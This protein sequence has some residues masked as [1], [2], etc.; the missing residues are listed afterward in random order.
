MLVLV[1]TKRLFNCELPALTTTTQTLVT[2]LLL[3]FYIIVVQYFNGNDELIDHPLNTRAN[4][5]RCGFFSILCCQ[6]IEMEQLT[7]DK[8]VLRM[9][10]QIGQS[11]EISQH[12]HVFR[13]FIDI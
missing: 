5:S 6:E 9:C 3:T 7:N 12:C 10:A 11:N 4:N 8:R 1:V 13:I 2:Y